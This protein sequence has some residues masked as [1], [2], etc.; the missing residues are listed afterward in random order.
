MDL[1]SIQAVASALQPE[2][3]L[4]PDAMVRSCEMKGVV[5]CETRLWL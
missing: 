1:F 4:S 2:L 3:D 5:R